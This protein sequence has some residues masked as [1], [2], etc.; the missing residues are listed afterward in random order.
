MAIITSINPVVIL[1]GGE[2]T[3]DDLSGALKTGST[4]VAADG[5]ADAALAWGYQP[6]A[7]IGDFDSISNQAQQ[8]IPKEKL[9]RIPEQDTTDFDKALRS[10]EAPLILG[11]GFTG[12]RLDHELA[13]LNVLVRH[14]NKR[15]ILI[16]PEDV[17]V[18][19]PSR[20]SLDLPIGSR[21]SLFP[22]SRVTG[23][24]FGLR[25][26]IEGLSFE[27]GK[28]TGTS[29]EVTGPVS[30]EMDQ[31][32][33]LLILPREALAQLIETFRPGVRAK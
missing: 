13:A 26:P 1:G 20:L 32:G 31:P 10:V 19:L 9:H 3:I 6:D 16:G 7:V 27:P 25:W 28:R 14:A 4:L 8:E 29:N 30:L 2:A 18:A 21:L 12:G 15:C 24:S 5:G 22:M 23:R 11:L 17:T 33:M